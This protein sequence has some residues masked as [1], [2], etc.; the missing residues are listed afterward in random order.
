[1]LKNNTFSIDYTPKKIVSLVPSQTE[2]LYDLGLEDSIVGVTKFCIHPLH[3]K[4]NKNIVGGTKSIHLEK[5]RALQPDIILC[6][7][8]ENTKEIVE[9]CS[10][11]APTHVSDIYNLDDSKELIALYGVIFSKTK[12]ASYLLRKINAQQRTFESFI[13][14]K[15]ILHVAYFIWRNPWMVAGKNTFIDHLLSI[16][17]F[18]NVYH[19]LDRYPK[20]TLTSLSN[21]VQPEFILLSSEPYPFKEEHRIEIQKQTNVSKVVFVDGEMFSWYGSRLEKAFAYF[22]QLRISL[23]ESI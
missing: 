17:R 21:K 11:I 10:S 20:V 15:P 22:K 4:K 5:I 23:E 6:N 12:E 3:A 1:M 9:D 19:H 7:K 18:Q 2:L 13:E 16:N 14:A 8:E